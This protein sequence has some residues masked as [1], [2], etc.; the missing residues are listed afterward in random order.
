M[1]CFL[2][3]QNLEKAWLTHSFHCCAFKFPSRHDPTRH[4]QQLELVERFKSECK[5]KGYTQQLVPVQVGR[6]TEEKVDQS[7]A[8]RS[9]R[10]A[11]IRLIRSHA[12]TK[13]NSLTG[14]SI[15]PVYDN[16]DNFDLDGYFHEPATV[17]NDYLEAI[18]GNLTLK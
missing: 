6:H 16:D 15:Q 10:S 7:A 9:R 1:S 13:N 5:A 4:V 18:C 8:M 2:L 17:P 14:V 3:Q 12:V 11:V